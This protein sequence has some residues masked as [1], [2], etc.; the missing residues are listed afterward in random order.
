MKRERKEEDVIGSKRTKGLDAE[1]G[2]A[3]NCRIEKLCGVVES[4]EGSPG[5]CGGRTSSG[6]DQVNGGVGVCGERKTV[7]KDTSASVKSR[8]GGEQQGSLMCHQCQRNDK[9]GVVFCSACDR[10]RYCY[11]CIA[12]WYPEKTRDDFRITCPFCHG[13]CN[14]KACLREYL[15]VRSGYEELD[16]SAKLEGLKYMLYKSLP[17]LRRIYEEQTAELEVESKL[18]GSRLT[19]TEVTRIKLDGQERLYW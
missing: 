15:A 12:R 9:S 18:Q 10:K 13:N 3:V 4:G 19:D 1:K 7:R 11:E 5:S 14:C 2:K 6:E 8:K 16:A 17:V